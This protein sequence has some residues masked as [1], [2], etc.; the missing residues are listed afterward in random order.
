MKEENRQ[1]CRRPA[2]DSPAREESDLLR[3]EVR[4]S[5]RRA[6]LRAIGFSGTDL[7]V[8]LAVLSVLAAIGVPVMAKSR[9]KSNLALCKANLQ[10]VGRAV[11]LYAG[12]HQNKLPALVSSPAPGG[13][14]GIRNKS[15]VTPG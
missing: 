3:A 6:V 4:A 2:F 12:E 15:R 7:L 5:R 13:W 1:F 11:L 14:W 10:Q 8:I 9:A